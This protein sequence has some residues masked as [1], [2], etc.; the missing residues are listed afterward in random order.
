MKLALCTLCFNEAPNI[1]ACHRNHRHW[2]GRFKH[3]FVEGF[4]PLYQLAN[5]QMVSQFGT[6]IDGMVE[7]LADIEACDHHSQYIPIGRMQHPT[8][9]EQHKCVGRE[10]YLRALDWPHVDSSPDWIA[11]ID[12]D[13]F[14]SPHSQEEIT[15]QLEDL[16]DHVTCAV[17][18]QIHLWR[19]PSI[20]NQPIQ[21]QVT[22]GYWSVPHT[23][24]WR[25]CDGL[26]YMPTGIPHSHNWPAKE[27]E[28]RYRIENGA[29]LKNVHC[30]HTGFAGDRKRYEADLR[31]YLERNESHTRA[32]YM[33][34][35]AAWLTWKPGDELPAGAKVLPYEGWIPNEKL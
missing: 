26:T 34:C 5:P 11:V 32:M 14:Y 16:P 20:A 27:G 25:W 24:F 23:R 17:V 31:Y 30:V 22:G 10:A 6:S 19:P 4:D 35:R 29:V 1:A 21:Y 15:R 3:V 12:A 33:A 28:Q 9:F 7:I 13:E 2:P 8:S 18:P